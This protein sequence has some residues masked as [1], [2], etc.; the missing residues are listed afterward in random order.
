MENK[1]DLT[2]K[3][4]IDICCGGKMFWYD[5]DNKNTIF[6][7][8]RE[9]EKGHIEYCPNWE[10]KPDVICDYRD[11]PFPDESFKLVVWDIPHIIKDSGGII[12]KK[13]GNLGENW[14]EDTKKAFSEVWR[15]LDK[16]GVMIFKYSD[17]SI[18]TSEMLNLFHTQPLFG[19]KTKKA[20]NSTYWFCFMKIE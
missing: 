19:T 2:E 10:C 14:K 15:I 13:Y 8:I 3:H 9:C 17:L 12:N 18:K 16:N 20:V 11:L 6:C 1:M 7:D 4:I 5:K